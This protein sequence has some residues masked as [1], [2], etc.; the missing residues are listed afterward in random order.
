[1][2]LM[3]S[4]AAM[5]VAGAAGAGSSHS[6]DPK[7]M[8]LRLSDLPPGFGR[9]EGHYTSSVREAKEARGVSVRDPGSMA[10]AE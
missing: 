7:A 10:V 6:A 5:G 1:V 9:T 2:A 3:A 8:V 4:V